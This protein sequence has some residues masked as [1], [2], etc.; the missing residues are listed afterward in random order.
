MFRNQFD[1]QYGVGARRGG[2]RRHQVGR[3]QP[4]RHRVLLRPRQGAE[5]AELLRHR[6]EAGLQ[7]KRVGGIARRTDHQEPDALF[8]RPTSTTTRHRRRS[9]PC[10]PTNP[11]ATA[12][13]GEWPSGRATPMATLKVDHRLERQNSIVRALRLRRPERRA[14]RQRSS[15]SRQV[16]DYS[17]MHS[18]IVEKNC[19]AVEQPGQ[20]LR[21]Q[22]MNHTLGTVPNNFDLSIAGRRPTS[23]R[24]RPSPQDFPRQRYQLFDTFYIN[25]PRHDFK[26]G[27]DFTFAHHTTMR[28]SS[29]PALRVHDRQAVRRQQPADLSARVHACR[30]PAT[31][32][33]QLALG[34]RLPQDTGAWP[35]A[36]AS[37]SACATTWT[38]TCG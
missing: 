13:N 23:A 2:E 34:R 31:T 1:A 12:N 30:R 21:F 16:S 38:R 37:T 7:Q 18:I 10:R 8:R 11:F 5:R 28:T 19:G 14:D 15:D 33:V 35:T 32:D 4:E 20:R 9:S 24:T 29:R 26:F 17:H 27:G 6:P 3:Q 22:Y 25:T 36:S